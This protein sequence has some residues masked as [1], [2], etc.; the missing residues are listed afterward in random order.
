MIESGK[1]LAPDGSLILSLEASG[2]MASAAVRKSGDITGYAENKA[3]HGHAETL[4][5]LVQEAL[6]QAGQSFADVRLVAAGCGPGSFTG[7]RVCLAAA[8]GFVIAHNLA[9]AGVNGLAA[10]AVRA[11]AKT[12]DRQAQYL[13]LADTRRGSWFAQVY[14]AHGVLVSPCAE[15]TSDTLAAWLEEYRN[16]APLFITGCLDA[17]AQDSLSFHGEVLH[18]MLD[19]RDIAEYAALAVN[20]PSRQISPFIPLYVNPARLGPPKQ[21]QNQAEKQAKKQASEPKSIR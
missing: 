13:S 11:A 20:D 3:R 14:D 12:G 7:I 10:L 17:A 19:A 8:S 21:N 4:I 18:H 16:N 1:I 6:Q 2:D 15:H 9:E 5:S